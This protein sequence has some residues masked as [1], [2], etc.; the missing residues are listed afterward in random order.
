M[1]SQPLA[2]FG[3]AVVQET[4]FVFGG[5]SFAASST[6]QV[7][8]RE[9]VFAF[10]G[11]QWQQVAN[12][13][14]ATDPGRQTNA[15]PGGRLRLCSEAWRDSLVIAFGQQLSPDGPT[16]LDDVWIYNTTSNSWLEVDTL[17]AASSGQRPSARSAA[18]CAVIG[19][20]LVVHG[21]FS[22]SSHEAV[23]DF[24]TL[25]LPSG[26][27]F[28]VVQAEGTTPPPP[29]YSHGGFALSDS[30][31]AV[32]GGRAPGA[33]TD[34]ILSTIYMFK[35]A[36]LTETG[37]M[38]GTWVV[39]PVAGN[40]PSR[41]DAA[42]FL[43]SGRLCSHGGATRSGL[44]GERITT[45]LVC[46][47]LNS[48]VAAVPL[49][50][51]L[52]V[53]PQ[54]SRP[55][56]A[57]SGQQLLPP[58]ATS[59]SPLPIRPLP[60]WQL[61][62]GSVGPSP[63]RLHGAAVLPSLT[64]AAP[65][66]VVF[67]GQAGLS[68]SPLLG[69][70]WLL[71]L[72]LDSFGNGDWVQ[73]PDEVM[74]PDALLLSYLAYGV[75]VTVFMAVCVLCIM[76]C[77]RRALLSGIAME[78]AGHSQVRTATPVAYNSQPSRGVSHSVINALPTM[79]YSKEQRAAKVAAGAHPESSTPL[80]P[81]PTGLATSPSH[82][83]VTTKGAW[84]GACT[85]DDDAVAHHYEHSLGHAVQGDQDGVSRH[86]LTDA[87]SLPGFASGAS[88]CTRHDSDADVSNPS[89][90]SGGACAMPLF[91]ANT[92]VLRDGS[93]GV[94]GAT[95]LEQPMRVD[96]A[97]PSPSHQAYN[98]EDQMLCTICQFEFEDGERLCVLPCLH[99]YHSLCVEAWLEEHRSCP[100]CK[101]DVMS[102]VWS[103]P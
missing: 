87:P 48:D 80:D 35:V 72:P 7:E 102:Y 60:R 71:P 81:E 57:L 58:P 76:R 98:P 24:W 31:F 14:H 34:V 91:R 4:A 82:I 40:A 96:T 43:W 36:Q 23:S 11:V 33:L 41:A 15:T 54:A 8:L 56:R 12:Y 63:R 20:V 83:A 84:P 9:D 28:P 53:G 51:H 94:A 85:L 100:L 13:A 93:G 70:V 38:R 64:G 3:L 74:Q 10:D 99:R 103:S 42:Y 89:P 52:R 73:M 25:H 90:L 19:D 29:C 45:T 32:Y 77:T 92:P 78:A 97:R 67:G 30:V 95:A 16:D 17:A 75:A 79:I 66:C 69:D 101:A 44:N 59:A 37:E 61:Y 6:G 2:A 88:S 26:Q 22:M 18:A 39:Q 1:H 86:P 47:D 68:G 65:T 55:A 46:I 5:A 21:G 62:M 50:R 49:A 27:W